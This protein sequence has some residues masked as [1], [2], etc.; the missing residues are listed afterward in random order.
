[1]QLFRLCGKRQR[2]APDAGPQED[3]AAQDPATRLR[4]GGSELLQ[5][6]RRVAAELGVPC[7]GDALSLDSA[8]AVRFAAALE[9]QLGWR[10]PA[11]LLFDY[12]SISELVDRG[13]QPRDGT[14]SFV[15]VSACEGGPGVLISACWELPGASDEVLW[16]RLEN[17]VDEVREI[18][19]CRWDWTETNTSE[20][21]G[22]RHAS[23]LEGAE[24]FDARF[25]GLTAAETQAADP[26]Q[27]LLL[28]TSYGALAAS[29]HDKGTLLGTPV[30]VFAGISNQ[31]WYHA[32][33]AQAPGAY[34]GTGTSAAVA[35]NRVSFALGLRGPSAA[36][37]TACSSSLSALSAAADWLRR[38]SRHGGRRIRESVAAGCELLLGPNSV[39]IRLAAN[40]LS[41]CTQAGA[42]EEYADSMSRERDVEPRAQAAVL[43]FGET[44]SSSEVLL[45]ATALNQDGRS[46]TL[47][48]PNGRSQED[49]GDSELLAGLPAAVTFVECHGTGT[50]LGDP[51]EVGA[52]RAVLGAPR[53]EPL[54]LGAGKTNL[55]HL[56]AAAGFA[57]LAK[58]MCSL[59]HGAVS[60]NLHFA[61]LNPHLERE[62]QESC[63]AIASAAP[64]LQW[65]FPL[66]WKGLGRRSDWLKL[67]VIGQ[68]E[69]QPGVSSF[70][71]GGTNAHARPPDS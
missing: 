9:T 25:F 26:Q 68:A 63:L 23:F 11:T 50:A 17:Q 19:L 30:A 2:L 4:T 57:G 48:A 70:G 21:L 20:S 36:T 3:L 32:S 40:M 37:D 31:E 64:G 33:F 6:V 14:S 43:T 18:P 8:A 60:A 29:G 47:T 59:Q 24:Q 53:E 27:R 71:F 69:N 28:S 45:A 66:P 49:V 16:S 58:V 52:L 51:I 62:I 42:G 13:L 12:P 55:G 44:A 34:T 67:A 39:L 65:I 22:Y 1:M 46:A 15:H 10:L 35:A 41:S 7:E 61:E 5:V 54:W 56:E 38:P